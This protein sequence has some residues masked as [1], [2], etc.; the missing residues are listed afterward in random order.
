MSPAHRYGRRRKEVT[1]EIEDV[2]QVVG[3]ANS[4]TSVAYNRFSF[5]LREAHR[6][7]DPGVEP[8]EVVNVHNPHALYSIGIDKSIPLGIS[9]P[10]MGIADVKGGV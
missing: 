2:F 6:S 9:R 1:C 7:A 4:I 5:G 8:R 10:G 3:I